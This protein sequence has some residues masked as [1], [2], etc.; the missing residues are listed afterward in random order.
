VELALKS[1]QSEEA[2]I[3]LLSVM[4]SWL[5]LQ[6]FNSKKRQIAGEFQFLLGEQQLHGDLKYPRSISNRWM[7]VNML[8]SSKDF[9]KA[10]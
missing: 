9:Q 6:M 7:W 10:C 1:G 8:S 5:D 4:R 2:D 3:H